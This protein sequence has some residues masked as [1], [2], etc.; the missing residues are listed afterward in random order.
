MV[1][2]SC[3]Y[4]HDKLMCDHMLQCRVNTLLQLDKC[5]QTKYKI[6]FLFRTTSIQNVDAINTFY[7]I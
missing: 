5:L 6:E 1:N 7:L 4:H 2:R 3:L